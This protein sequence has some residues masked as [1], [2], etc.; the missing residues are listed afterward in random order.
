MKKRS[1]IFFFGV[2]VVVFL[3]FRYVRKPLNHENGEDVVRDIS[4]ENGNADGEAEFHYEEKDAEE[5]LSWLDKEILNV[6]GHLCVWEPLRMDESGKEYGLTILGQSEPKWNYLFEAEEKISNVFVADKKTL[7]IPVYRKDGTDFRILVLDSAGKKVKEIALPPIYFERDDA[8]GEMFFVKSDFGA[9]EN[10]LYLSKSVPDG[11]KFKKQLDIYRQDGTLLR[12]ENL[13]PMGTSYLPDGRGNYLEMGDTLVLRKT[14]SGEKTFETAFDGMLSWVDTE[15]GLLYTHGGNRND[16]SVYRMDD[17]FLHKTILQFG[18]DTLFYPEDSLLLRQFA[19]GEEGIAFMTATLPK[20]SFQ[21]TSASLY[22]YEKV[23]GGKPVRDKILKVTVPYP[24]ELLQQAKRDYE[25]KY[26]D[27][28]VEIDA[29]YNNL[30]QF[31]ENY[32]QYREQLQL[33]LMNGEVG[34]LVQTASV[35]DYRTVSKSDVFIDLEPL[36]KSSEIRGELYENI[37]QGYEKIGLRGIPMEIMVGSVT[38][39]RSKA[40]EISWDAEIDKVKW[41]DL[42]RL[43]KRLENEQSDVYL[44]EEAQRNMCLPYLL[45]ANMPNVVDDEKKTVHLKQEWFMTLIRDWKEIQNS[46][47]LFRK[48]SGEKKDSVRGK[49]MGNALFSFGYSRTSLREDVYDVGLRDL[50]GHGETE[51]RSMFCG[52]R[53]ENRLGRAGQV[54]SISTKS[55]SQQEAWR[56]LEILLSNSAQKKGR[57][58][59][60]NRNTMEQLFERTAR[61]FFSEELREELKKQYEDIMNSVEIVSVN[62]YAETAIEHAL[63]DYLDDKISLEEAINKAEHDVRIILNE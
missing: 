59:S 44:F 19:V 54:F 1:L 14:E 32:E 36:L 15:H 49:D 20:D 29:Q 58:N 53:S 63:Q 7:Y 2:L 39:H 23:S 56:F 6:E 30:K 57:A 4:K 51:L 9:D 18:E 41:S 61:G 13:V 3:M 60:I 52:E 24:T 46:P 8:S 45:Y 16:F 48:S 47:W 17:G 26:R 37:L 35:L 34:D 11:E 25:R 42:I 55:N 21:Y 33:R 28:R 12:K 38:F 5:D 50:S 43:A 31:D 27:T 62:E 40:E 22:L 10:Y